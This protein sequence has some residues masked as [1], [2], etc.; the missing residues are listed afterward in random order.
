M[1]FE[2]KT[3]DLLPLGAFLLRLVRSFGATLI[4]VAGSLT[5]GT[6]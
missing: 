6:A 4:V 1:P 5:L 3:D 2:S